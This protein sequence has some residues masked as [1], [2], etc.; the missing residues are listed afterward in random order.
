MWIH[1][2]AYAVREAQA[3]LASR[4][5]WAYAAVC[6]GWGLLA[7]PLS[8]ASNPGS[9]VWMLLPL[10]L[11]GI[12]LAGL[13]GGVAAWHGDA[14]EEALLTTRS[15]RHLTRALGKWMVWSAVFASAT[16][17]LILPSLPATRPL[18]PLLMLWAYAAGEIAIFTA[19][20][21][22]LGRTCRDSVLAHSL[23]LMLG[24]LAIAGGGILAWIAAHVPFL[25]DNPSLWTALLMVH[26]VE[27]VR[28]STLFSL[29]DLPFDAR[30]LPPLA[31]GWLA[32]PDLWFGS[33]SF[34]LSA[35][36]LTAFAKVNRKMDL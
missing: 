23:A 31:A 11:Y 35:L 5:A 32:H 18:P 8:G 10:L 34:A 3:V 14:A 7:S 6:L 21:L 2:R 30:R 12:P 4:I 28:V 20:G 15:P 36:A 1:F 16:L 24:L 19:F 26:P 13:L 22:W 9:S 27:V 29:E 25:Q 33:L 17:C